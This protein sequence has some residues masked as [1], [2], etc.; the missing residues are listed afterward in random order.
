MGHRVADYTL[1]Q[2][3][4]FVAVADAG[5]ISG[6]AAQRRVTPTAVASAITELE[7]ILRT[8]LFVRRRA[9]GV[10]L[11]PTGAYLQKRAAILLRDAEELRLA[12]ASGG[13][14]L[15]GPLA[16]G[17]Y[18][19]VSPTIV[20]P[21]LR[22]AA[23][24]HPNV[25]VHFSAHNQ[26]ELPELLFSGALDLAIVYDMALPHGLES[27]LL[28]SVRPYV[29]L[30]ADHRLAEHA[31]VSLTDVA[32]DAL[33]L[34]DLPPAAQHTLWIF[35]QAGVVPRVAHRTTDFEL[36]RSLVARG[37]GYSLLV[38]RPAIDCSYEGLPLVAREISP[39]VQSTDV[40]MV[41]P[42]GVRLTD[43]ARAL[44]TFAAGQ[45]R[46]SDPRH[47]AVG[48]RGRFGSNTSTP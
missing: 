21:L 17:C 24:H 18:V 36:T 30:P 47:G 43:R 27:V 46:F 41:W 38:Q 39:A 5:S 1:R 40:Q 7:R 32:D 2:L 4:Y 44:V 48:A 14:E 8:Q 10:T 31:T 6:A 16:V 37:L 9:H 12:A 35:E 34:L 19:T 22:W 20:P 23:E 29:V 45:A 25:E 15:A 13:T 42:H 33:I 26:V 3:D 11:T 28:Y